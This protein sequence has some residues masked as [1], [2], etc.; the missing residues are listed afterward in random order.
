MHSVGHVGQPLPRVEVKLASPTS[1]SEGI[2][3]GE[4]RVRGPSVFSRYWNR[5]DA[6]AESFDEDNFFKTGDVASYDKKVA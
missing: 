6:T 4:L 5:P 3:V 1:E 2:T